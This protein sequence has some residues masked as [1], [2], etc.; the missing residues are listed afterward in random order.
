MNRVIAWFAAN[1]VA[2]NLVMGFAVLGGITA[3]LLIPVKPY[4]DFEIPAVIVGMDYPGAAPVEVESGVCRR[5]EDAVIGI[6]GVE[7]VRSTAAEGRCTV[8][9]DLFSDADRARVTD[10]IENRVQAIDTFPREAEKL[11]VRQVTPTN[12]VAEVVVTGPPGERQL[13]ELGRR[14]RDDLLNLPGITQVSL[15][16]TRPYEISV[17]VSEISLQRNGMTFD[18]VA[19]ALRRRSVDV[20]SGS[21]RSDRGEILLRSRGQ[22]YHG[23]DLERLA[24][25]VRPDGTRVLLRDVARV[26]DGFADTGQ[27][28]SFDGRPAALLQVARVGG[29]DARRIVATVRQYVTEASSRYP[30]GAALHLWKDESSQLA[31]RL[32]TLIDAG[33]QGLMLV[34]ILLMLFLRPHL[35]L[36]VAI[37][38]PVAILGAVFLVWLFGLSLD[39][40]SVIGF[41]VALGMLVDDA[42]VVGESAHAA[43]RGGAGQLQGAVS[44]TQR[45]VVPVTFGV[46]T[47]IAAFV[48]LMFV[49]GV[50][51]QTLAIIAVVV[52]CCLVFSLI[53]CQ[54]VLPAHLG[55]HSA[56]L[57]LGDFGLVV[58][59]VTLVGAFLVAPDMRSAAAL[60]VMAVALASA[61]HLIGWLTRLGAAFATIQGRF[62]AALDR[63][64][65]RRFRRLAATALRRRDITCALAF[66]ALLAAFAVVLAGHLPFTLLLASKGD[67][68][69]VQLTMPPGVDAAATRTVLA[70]VE[71]AAV[72]L[73]SELLTAHQ[74]PVILHVMTA[75]GGHPSAAASLTAVAEPSG[76]HLGEVVLQL[77]PGER[78]PIDTDAVAELLRPDVG[79]VPEGARLRLVTDSRP[80]DPDI[81]IRVSGHDLDDLTAAVADLRR[82]LGQYPGVHQVN[83]TLVPGKDEFE[84]SVTHAGEALGISLLDVGRQLRQAFYGEE[85][86]RIQRGEDDVRLMV[87]YTEAERRSLG[88][89]DSMRIR[90][91][92]GSEVPFSAVTQLHPRQGLSAIN[93]TDG[94]RSANVTARV[95]PARTSANAVLESLATE[96]LPDFAG[97]HP[98][99]AYALDSQREQERIGASIVPLLL[100]AL[101]TVY[102]MLS[103]P[104][105]SYTQAWVVLMVVPFVWVG[106]I[107]GHVLLKL[108]GHVV[109]LSMPSIFGM[110]AA[111]GV[112]INATLVVLHAV[113]RRRAAGDTL[114]D[115]LLAAAVSRFRPILITT[116]TTFVGLAPLMFSRSVAAQPLA[117]LAVSLAFG[118]LIA[119]V[120][121]L[122]AVPAAWLALTGI[123]VRAARLTAA[124]GSWRGRG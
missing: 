2:A 54:C 45:V 20:P 100:L 22:A 13:K 11:L 80:S 7:E 87:R 53:E 85:V 86:Q 5:I 95:D 30:D 38:I 71:T 10:E 73:Q 102:A 89:L 43:Q 77:T 88:A 64:V 41:I 48:P 8:R 99:I 32:G 12:V 94:F 34:L 6:A 17:E 18:E 59:A 62:E 39:A 72:R 37:G 29:Q 116:V 16:N 78:R 47:T 19:Q 97:R 52:I 49:A 123:R 65:E 21:I 124:L 69:V 55:H 119:A 75:M 31:N 35:A 67:R 91:P 98:G 66:V 56:H 51:G 108:S 96:F 42:V 79:P 57:P 15:V 83:D 76:P 61:A 112:A 46:L 101:F 68:V 122:L 114:E 40:I 36:W 3:I 33:A 1:H 81:D 9:L 74:E 118:V 92:D 24:I 27:E 104:L 90:I 117:P 105:R 84:L 60:A 63:F 109:G 50:I 110:V 58:L 4:P 106:A 120:A 107:G 14:V 115:A 121:A 93:R 44:G 82:A 113:N 28:L 26:V 23:E 111:S 25:R 103:M 70:R